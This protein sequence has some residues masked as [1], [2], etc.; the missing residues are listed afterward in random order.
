MQYDHTQSHT[1]THMHITLVHK[2]NGPHEFSGEK[3]HLLKFMANVE[4][5]VMKVVGFAYSITGIF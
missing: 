2:A 4:K 3:I 1:L 5:K